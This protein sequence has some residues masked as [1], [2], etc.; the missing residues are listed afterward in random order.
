MPCAS[1]APPELVEQLHRHDWPEL[2]SSAD[3]A[4]IP[5]SGV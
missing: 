4:L 5:G 1:V 2:R 3:S